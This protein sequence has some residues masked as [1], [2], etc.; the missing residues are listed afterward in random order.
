MISGTTKNV[1]KY[2][3]LDPVFI[4][5]IF[6]KIHEAYGDILRKYVHIWESDILKVL[7]GTCTK[8]LIF[9]FFNFWEPE[10]LNIEIRKTKWQHGLWYWHFEESENWKFGNC[11]FEK[12][13][14]KN[15]HIEHLNNKWNCPVFYQT[16]WGWAA[17]NDDIWLNKIS[18]V[19]DMNSISI[20][21]HEMEIW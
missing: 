19:L 12:L 2:G 3:P 20:K 18:E 21:N 1:T 16:L 10:S 14:L 13:K 7:E 4:T 8:P 15:E 5:E 17:E 9:C 6:Q 11:I